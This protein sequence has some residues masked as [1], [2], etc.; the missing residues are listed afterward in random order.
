LD[1][2]FMPGAILLG[3]IFLPFLFLAS[4]FFNLLIVWL[5]LSRV[6]IKISE[7][8]LPIFA[9]TCIVGMIEVILFL[10]LYSIFSFTSSSYLFFIL[11]YVSIFLVF[12]LFIP[13]FI[14]LNKKQINRYSFLMGLLTNPAIPFL[15]I[16][17]IH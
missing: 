11:S 7:L 10:I 6:K 1:I 15:L 3:I 12:R 4:Y 17:V 2:A 13:Q 16:S 14:K 5:L 8:F 9:Y